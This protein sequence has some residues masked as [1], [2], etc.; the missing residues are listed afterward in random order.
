MTQK[1]KRKRKKFI[2]W[3]HRK[4]NFVGDKIN[5]RSPED[6]NHLYSVINKEERRDFCVFRKQFYSVMFLVFVSRHDTISGKYILSRSRKFLRLMYQVLLI[7][8]LQIYFNHYF[9][10]LCNRYFSN[11]L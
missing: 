9:Q 1:R 11:I 8:I 4:L 5:Y 3:F 2:K 10:L 7:F 6:V